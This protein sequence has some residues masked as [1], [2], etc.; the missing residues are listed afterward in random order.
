MRVYLIALLLHGNAQDSIFSIF[1]GLGCLIALVI[2]EINFNGTTCSSLMFASTME[3]QNHLS[4]VF[5]F[6][7]NVL[8]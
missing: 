7:E 6:H 1:K 5:I 4:K 2:Q 8:I 3:F